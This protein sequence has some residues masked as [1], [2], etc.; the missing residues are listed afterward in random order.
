MTAYDPY[1]LD[2][3]CLVLGPFFIAVTACLSRGWDKGLEQN[4]KLKIALSRKIWNLKWFMRQVKE[5][6]TIFFGSSLCDLLNKPED[7]RFSSPIDE[8]NSFCLNA[9]QWEQCCQME[10][11]MRAPCVVLSFRAEGSLILM[12]HHGKVT[13][14]VNRWLARQCNFKFRGMKFLVEVFEWMHKKPTLYDTNVWLVVN[15][16]TLGQWV[17]YYSFMYNVIHRFLYFPSWVIRSTWR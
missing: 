10:R 5:E 9:F 7:A 15:E 8:R 12:V 6:M 14:N 16:S 2:D 3:C 13:L 4:S 1:E 17:I 11:S